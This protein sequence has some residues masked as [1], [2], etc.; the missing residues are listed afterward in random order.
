MSQS[1]NESISGIAGTVFQTMLGMEIAPAEADWTPDPEA[2]VAQ[3]QL[4]GVWNGA[5]VLETSKEQAREFAG[6]F[7]SCPAPPDV[8]GDVR[9]VMGELANMIGGNLK[10]TMAHGA[11]LSSPQVTEGAAPEGAVDRQAF[12]GSNGLFWV[13]RVEKKVEAATQ[14]DE[15][16]VS[17]DP[18]IRR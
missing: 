9:D 17:D 8:D 1:D 11:T 15:L 14:P 2:V 6:A 16:P 10:S 12:S 3:V 4:T 7:L 13:A 18:G 5:V